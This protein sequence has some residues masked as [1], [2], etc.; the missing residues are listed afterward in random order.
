MTFEGDARP[1]GNPQ[2]VSALSRRAQRVGHEL[3]RCPHPADEEILA[4]ADGTPV[5]AMPNAGLPQYVEGRFVYLANPEYFAEFAA[6]A[7]ALGARLVGGCCGTTPAHTRA[8]R[9]R[10]ASHLPVEK[11]APGAEVQ[12]Q[13]RRHVDLVLEEGRVRQVG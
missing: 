6:R 5:S 13:P 9:E 1:Y 11:L 3:R 2:H 4:A 8:M 12:V 10:L 7:V